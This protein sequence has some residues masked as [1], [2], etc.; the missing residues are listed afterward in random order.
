L[1]RRRYQVAAIAG[2]TFREHS[3]GEKFHFP[4]FPLSQHRKL[5]QLFFFF[6]PP[7]PCRSCGHDTAGLYLFFFFPLRIMVVSLFLFFLLDCQ[8]LSGTDQSCP[9][10]PHWTRRTPSQ[11]QANISSFP[12]TALSHPP[13]SSFSP[14]RSFQKEIVLSWFFFLARSQQQSLF[15][16]R[17]RRLQALFSFFSVVMRNVDFFL[18]YRYVILIFFL[19]EI[20]LLSPLSSL[21]PG[22]P[23]PNSQDGPSISPPFLATESLTPLF[24]FDC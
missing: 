8:T 20:V 12:L 15:L 3:P 9:G 2:A 16:V 14:V 18:T 21:R 24:F 5:P 10:V 1:Q 19:R 17:G 23:S 7:F 13:L 6:S 11:P 4:L 22:I